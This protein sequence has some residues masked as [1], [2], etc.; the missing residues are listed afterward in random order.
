MPQ[1]KAL[2]QQYGQKLAIIGIAMEHKGDLT[3]WKQAIRK[4]G[5]PGLQLSELQGDKGPVISGYNVMGFPTY[6]LLD[7]KGALV[8]STY[9]LDEVTKKLATLGSL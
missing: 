6:M 7:P 5:A 8:M 9:N 2:H 1:V 3:E 4:H